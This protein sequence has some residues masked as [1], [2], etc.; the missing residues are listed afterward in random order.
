MAREKHRVV[1]VGG[2]FGGLYAA[3]SL[4]HA[5]VDVTLI[6]RRNHHVFQ[7]L[8]YQ[9]ATAALNPADIA[10][11]IRKILRHQKNVRVM[12]A[13]VLG[14]D[15]PG[16]KVLL[17]GA[18]IPYDT[19]IL[20]CGATHSYFGKNQWAP[21]APGLKSIEDA[22]QI[23]RRVLLAYEAAE[24]DTDPELRKAWLT[25]VVVGGGPT[26]V[27]LAGA[28][29]EI[30]THAL[31]KDF[32]T[33]NP[34]EARVLLLE[35]ADRILPTYVPELS[36]EAKKELE[37][38]GVEVRTGAKVTNIDD[39]GV[40]IGDSEHI[41]A[42]TVLW[43]AGVAAAPVARSLGVPLDRAGRVI[44][45]P[46]LTIKQY[47]DIFVIGDLAAAKDGDK[48]VPGLAA[49][50]VQ[51]GKHTAENIK[52]KVE[53]QPL[54][55]FHYDDK[56]NLATIGR[57]AAV[58]DFGKIKLRGVI[59]WFAWLFIH[60]LLLIG[61]RNRF[62]VVIEWAWTYLTYQRGARLIT[63]DTPPLLGPHASSSRPAPH[64]EL[65]S[66]PQSIGAL[67]PTPAAAAPDR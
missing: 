1:I 67:P 26:G 8:L 43:A 41:A 6:D 21:F 2:G 24:L 3:R 25:F 27:E 19:L 60:V 35:G 58:A 54:R 9:V 20:A 40:R 57:A 62:M 23:R 30:G 11:P 14:V 36:A 53:G 13:E 29:K 47:P 31:Q 59:A 50:A 4:R 17:D 63:G 51:E 56:G 12:L 39:E 7:P 10:S 28:L 49:A 42:K 45:E 18:A 64:Q 52:R 37:E 32:R 38:L 33:I 66:A 5:D 55:P 15:A 61:F 65:A 34:A 16:K 22:L 48:P 44:V 46:D